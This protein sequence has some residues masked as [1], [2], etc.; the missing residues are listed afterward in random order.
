MIETILNICLCILIVA[1]TLS[2]V[3]LIMTMAAGWLDKKNGGKK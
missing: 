3:A 1:I 2:A